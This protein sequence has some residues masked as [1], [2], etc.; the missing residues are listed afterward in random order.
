MHSNNRIPP[1][2]E[3][4]PNSYN[5]TQSTAY[6]F[7]ESGNQLRRMPSYDIEGRGRNNYDERPEVEGPCTKNYPS[8]LFGGFGYLFLWFCPVH[9]HAYGCHLIA[10]GRKEGSIQLCLQIH[11]E[12]S[13]THVL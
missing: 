9:G 2:L 13:Q 10:G 1:D 7:T 5:P 4:I 11:G 6:Y 12:S 8:V 3:P